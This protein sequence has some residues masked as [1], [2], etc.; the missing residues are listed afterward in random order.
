[1]ALQVAVL[2]TQRIAVPSESAVTI[3]DRDLDNRSYPSAGSVVSL[4][5]VPWQILVERWAID[6]GPVERKSKS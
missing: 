6:R 4:L 5:A 2:S 1:M 3:V